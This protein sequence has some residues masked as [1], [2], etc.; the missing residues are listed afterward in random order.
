MPSMSAVER[1]F[2]RSAPWKL[3][4]ERVVLPWAVRDVTLAGEVL[5]IG[6]GNG[7]MARA[8]SR[9]FPEARVTTTDIDPVMVRA[10]GRQLEDRP[11][12]SAQQADVTGLPF[13]DETF[14]HVVSFLMLHH[15]VDWPAALRE[16]RRVLRPGGSFIGY[17]LTKSLMAEWVHI[18]DRSPYRL[19]RPAELQDEL[20]ASGFQRA[21]LASA[22]SGHVV[23][24]TAS[25]P[26]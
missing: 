20:R 22:W 25:A 24:F 2:C 14:D 8:V 7:A 17:D 6:G 12:A 11:N 26:D 9:R 1:T 13:P 23:R 16:A 15:V 18:L 3:F 19:I 4:T 21:D 5:E 10:A